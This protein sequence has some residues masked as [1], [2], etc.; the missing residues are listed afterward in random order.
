[1]PSYGG[2]P[3]EHSVNGAF[4][5]ADTLSPELSGALDLS[6]MKAKAVSR[7]EPPFLAYNS[8]QK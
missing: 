6:F 2:A 7:A 5:R 3:A 4:T 8:N 1:M